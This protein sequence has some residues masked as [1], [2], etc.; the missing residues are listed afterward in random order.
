MYENYSTGNLPPAFG[1][2]SEDAWRGYL[3]LGATAA[4]GRSRHFWL[5]ASAREFLGD[6][7]QGLHWDQWVIVTAD[8]SFRF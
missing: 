8:V 6:Q 4:I 7:A 5:G 1:A 3:K 2:R